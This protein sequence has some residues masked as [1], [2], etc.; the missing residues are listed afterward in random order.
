MH[1]VSRLYYQVLHTV[2]YC[3]VQCLLHVIDIF[4]IS[5]FYMV[6]DDLCGKCSSYRPV[7]IC[8]CKGFF[9]SSDI[10]CTA[11]IEG[12]TEADYQQFVFTDLVSV[13]RIILAGIP[14]ISSE[15]V[16]VCI[17]TFYQFLLL[18]CQGIPCFLGC[19]ALFV[20]IICS[21]LNI[22]GINQSCHFVSLRLIVI[23]SFTGCFCG[24]FFGCSAC[25]N[26][27]CFFCCLFTGCLCGLC[28]R[29]SFCSC[30][31]AGCLCGLFFGCSFC[32]Y[33]LAG[34]LCRFCLRRS[35]CSLSFRLR[36]C[37]RFR[38]SLCLSLCCL[39]CAAAA[40]GQ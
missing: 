6:D 24:F 20:C 7:W 23:C 1:Q 37:G 16:R 14:G 36:L 34:C 22:N 28:F 3:T 25:S 26:C 2:F 33:F 11:V 40:S 27:N 18:I 17:L 29:C 32:S 19:L 35:F 10:S 12:C 4:I 38:C 15:I 31:F 39:C 8:I 30:F 5:C 13:Q 21:F 9:D